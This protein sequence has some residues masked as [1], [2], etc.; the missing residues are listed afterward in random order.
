MLKTELHIYIYIYLIFFTD[1]FR[2]RDT[3][4]TGVISIGFEDFLGVAL[5]CSV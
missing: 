5:N 4:Q 3:E 2:V 1:A